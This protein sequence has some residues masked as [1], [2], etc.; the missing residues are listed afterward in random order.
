MTTAELCCDIDAL[1]AREREAHSAAL[2]T[3]REAALTRQVVRGEARE[4]VRILFGERGDEVLE[5]ITT[6]TRYEAR[7]CPF[8]EISH[9]RTSG[10]SV[11]MTIAG[12]PGTADSLATV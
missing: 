2:G 11:R 7:C 4:E 1:T 10:G 3:W 5:A 12:P 9:D 8:L 6:F